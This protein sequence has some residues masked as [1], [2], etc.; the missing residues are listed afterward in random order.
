MK[1]LVTGAN[2]QLG[3]ELRVAAE[4]SPDCYIFTDVAELDITDRDSLEDF[5]TSHEIDIIIN[6]AAYTAVERAEQEQAL[7]DTINHQAVATLSDVARERGVMIIHI[8]TDF[9]FDG[10]RAT[11]YT[12]QD[13]PSPINHYGITKWAG[14]RA[15]AASDARYITIRTG[16]LYS[17][18]GNNF[19]LTILR[20]ANERE[21]IRVVDDQRGT[22]T[23]AADLAEFL[24]RII[25]E[26][27]VAGYEGTYHYSNM[28]VASWYEFAREIVRLAGVD[29]RVLP[30]TTEEY[31]TRARRPRYSVLDKD[32][33]RSRF[34]VE[35]PEWRASLARC[36]EKIMSS[37]L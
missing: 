19:V 15:L 23:Y 13:L 4:G 24:V 14:E 31:P 1:I 29:C 26:R 37:K 32:F 34:G 17:P 28:G 10:M 36:I 30:C 33:T 16:W 9:V 27:K 35:I 21:E 3:S 20:L 18:Y 11:P 22:P 8:S 2:G 5:V 6:C 25:S 12:E 7:C